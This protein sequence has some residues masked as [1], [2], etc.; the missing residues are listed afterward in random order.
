MEGAL[1]AAQRIA[2]DIVRDTAAE[3]DAASPAPGESDNAFSLRLFS[4]WV[5]QQ[6]QGLFDDYRRRLN[7]SLATQAREQITQRAMLGAAEGLF[8]EA[9][10]KLETLPFDPRGVAV[11]KG[12]SAL[13]PLAQQPFGDVLK[14]LFDDVAAFNGTSCALSNF[15]DEHKLPKDY[16][17]AIMRDIAAAWAEFSRDLN[18]LLLGKGA[19]G[20]TPKQAGGAAA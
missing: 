3:T 13:T 2:R 9:L 15:P 16:R 12:R 17:Q 10:A 6:G 14:Q 5:E 7:A 4:A 11:E 18:G 19:A 20:E 8:A 1:E